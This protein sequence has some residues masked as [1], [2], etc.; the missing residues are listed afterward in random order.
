MTGNIVHGTSSRWPTPQRARVFRSVTCPNRTKSS[1]TSACGPALR[2][3][4]T[5]N[6]Y[7]LTVLCDYL[8][9]SKYSHGSGVKLESLAGLICIKS[10]R[11]EFSGGENFRWLYPFKTL[12]KQNDLLFKTTRK[13]KNR[14]SI[15]SIYFYLLHYRM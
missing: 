13:Q 14:M 15:Y 11:R 7:V 3:S 10:T 1:D 4:E 8:R 12:Q 9:C 5:D 2:Q 6:K